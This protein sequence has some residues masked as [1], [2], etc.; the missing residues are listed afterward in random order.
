MVVKSPFISIALPKYNVIEKDS[1]V[2]ETM[3]PMLQ[4]T[5]NFFYMLNLT[6][7]IYPLLFEWIEKKTSYMWKRV[8]KISVIGLIC[9][10]LRPPFS[11]LCKVYHSVVIWWRHQMQTF[12]ALLAICARN[13]PGTGEF[14]A[15]R[16]VTRSFEVF[17]DLHLNKQLSKQSWGWWFETISCSLWR[18]CNE[19]HILLLLQNRNAVFYFKYR[20]F[21]TWLCTSKEN[22]QTGRSGNVAHVVIKCVIDF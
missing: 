13:S 2:V 20:A 18:H 4:P 3:I 17:F 11:R 22:G 7:I 14:P 10:L 12:S 5:L 16:P 21:E 15:Q 19:V 6:K 9:S 1:T 8:C